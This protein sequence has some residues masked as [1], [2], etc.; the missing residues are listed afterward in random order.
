M[1][2]AKTGVPLGLDM[3]IQEGEIVLIVGNVGPVNSLPI[4]T[5][6]IKI[7]ETTSSC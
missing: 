1:E 3:C 5:N 4:N 6:R 2:G 7:R